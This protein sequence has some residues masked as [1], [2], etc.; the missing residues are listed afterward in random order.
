MV[1]VL[2][3]RRDGAG[4]IEMTGG[5]GRAVYVNR[6]EAQNVVKGNVLYLDTTS[7]M[8]SVCWN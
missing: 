4:L 7:A 8:S 5:C 1:C 3:G 6:Y 2:D